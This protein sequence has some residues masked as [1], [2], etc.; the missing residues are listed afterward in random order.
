[1]D[2]IDKAIRNALAK[3]DASDPAFREKVYRTIFGALDKASAANSA[4]TPEAADRRRKALA[5][6]IRLIEGEYEELQTA[7]SEEAP[8]LL[9]EGEQELDESGELPIGPAPEIEIQNRHQPHEFSEA[10]GSD[11]MDPAERRMGDRRKRSGRKRR[12]FVWFFVIALIVATVGMA[13][14]WTHESGILLSQAERDTS[15][16]NPPR[17][18]SSEDYRPENSEQPLSQ[19]LGQNRKWVDI[20]NPDDPTTVSA[21]A[22]ATAEIRGEGKDKV[23]RIRSATAEAAVIFD[24]GPG[25]LQEMAGK[26]AVFDIVASSEENKPT[27]ISV[28]CEFGKLG[29]CIRKRYSVGLTPSEFLFEIKLA[30]AAATEAGSIAIVSDVNGTGMAV[31]IRN[32]RVAAEK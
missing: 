28:T 7:P 22:G 5:D 20:F 27:E 23:L 31:D 3:G 14:W 16:P 32:I 26:I 2:A 13:A 12:P 24:V 9:A 18:L 11:L 19:S 1:M 29:T 4:I 8:A 10:A 25:V 17:T 6:R 15:V 30:D 21:Q